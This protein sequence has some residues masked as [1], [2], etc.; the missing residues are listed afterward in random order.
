MTDAGRVEVWADPEGEMPADG[1]WCDAPDA[2][3]LVIYH[4]WVEPLAECPMDFLCRV[5]G[6]STGA[7]A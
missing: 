1:R 7:E 3:E 2:G 6:H 5:C 4:R